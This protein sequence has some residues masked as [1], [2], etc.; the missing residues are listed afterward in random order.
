MDSLIIYLTTANKFIR[1]KRGTMSEKNFWLIVNSA[2][3]FGATGFYADLP[4]EE[5]LGLWAKERRD[6]YAEMFDSMQT[7]I[8]DK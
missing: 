5:F 8:L 7:N 4:R 6:E 3:L 1:L 2:H